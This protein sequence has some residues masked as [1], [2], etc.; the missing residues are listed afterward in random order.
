MHDFPAWWHA[1]TLLSF[2][3]PKESSKEK[4]SRFDTVTVLG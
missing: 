1:S 2:A 3:C 4:G